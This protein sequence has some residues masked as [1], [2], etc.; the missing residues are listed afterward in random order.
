[1]TT[2]FKLWVIC[3]LS[4]A[5]GIFFLLVKIWRNRTQKL[6]ELV[7]VRTEE[8]ESSLLKL[9]ASQIELRSNL[10]FRKR[11]M[12]ILVHDL[13][14]P[15]IFIH[16]LASHLH[17]TYSALTTD[18]IEHLTSELNN[19]TFSISAF[20]SDMLSWMSMDQQFSIPVKTEFGLNSFIRNNCSVYFD[21]A[22]KKNIEIALL[23]DEEFCI[24]TDHSLFLIIIRNLLDNSI[25]NTLKGSISIQGVSNK[26]SQ[27]VTLQDTG[28]GMS[29]EKAIEIEN[30][31][32]I[33]KSTDSS[34]IGFR[35]V[36]DL[37]KKLDGSIKVQSNSTGT[38]II[39]CLPPR[40]LPA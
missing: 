2:E 10:D 29:K 16:R 5:I 3:I 25:K 14:S 39:I 17:E 13:K 33:R 31:I 30:G 24:N 9:E 22:S 6:Q 36:H 37:L 7:A 18:E 1:M 35:I 34:Q 23:S 11:M 20:V 19:A 15:I 26:E 4:C 32:I 38:K 40:E 12:N 8:L 21:I 27:Q 28:I